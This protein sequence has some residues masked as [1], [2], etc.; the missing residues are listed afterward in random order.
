MLATLP[1]VSAWRLA[2][3]QLP[4]GI[5]R[6]GRVASVISN[7]ISNL[8]MVTRVRYILGDLKL[9]IEELLKSK[10]FESIPNRQHQSFQSLR[11]NVFRSINTSANQDLDDTHPNVEH[12]QAHPSE[13]YC[14]DKLMEKNH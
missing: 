14:D 1:P 5:D 11:S 9:V 4:S 6:N 12:T 8:D 3:A 13:Y 10:V 7:T 2:L